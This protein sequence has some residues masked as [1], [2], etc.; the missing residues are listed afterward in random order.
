M[1]SA[2]QGVAG[3]G[4][5]ALV[6]YFGHLGAGCAG[7]GRG[8]GC[9]HQGGGT[10]D[11]HVSRRASE[12]RRL[13]G[14]GALGWVAGERPYIIASLPTPPPLSGFLSFSFSFLSSFAHDW[15]H[16]VP[17]LASFFLPSVFI[18]SKHFI[19]V[20]RISSNLFIE[21]PGFFLWS[22]PL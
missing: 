17:F 8:E 11:P 18:S 10:G 4:G 6:G 20:C 7:L 13:G 21:F 16:S 12:G 15:L 9:Q 5:W 1:A 2:V 19:S 14:D 3:S 22:D